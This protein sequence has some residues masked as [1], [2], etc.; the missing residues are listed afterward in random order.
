PDA[1][2][3]PVPKPHLLINDGAG[4]LVDRTSAYGLNY[5]PSR[6]RM[7]LWLDANDDGRLDL[8]IPTLRRTGSNDLPT[9]L[10]EQTASG[11]FTNV[12]RAVGLH[13]SATTQFAQLTNLTGDR[14]LEL[15]TKT[16]VGSAGE[17]ESHGGAYPTHV[18]DMQ[19]VPFTDR[20]ASSGVPTV[21]PMQ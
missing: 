11:T 1:G 17:N 19:T 13:L 4:H 10:F 8:L 7:P 18:Y 5:T 6:G 12:S 16:T 21:Q 2:G 14:G 3:R 9:A 15:V 20:L